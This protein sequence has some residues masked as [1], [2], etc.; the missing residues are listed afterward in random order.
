MTWLQFCVNFVNFGPVTP[1]FKNG[2]GVQPLVSFVK[3]N[4]SDKLSQ[5]PL[6]RFSPNFLCSVDM[7]SQ[8]TDLTSLFP[9]RS[10]DVVWGQNG[11]NRPTII[12]I[13]RLG[14]PKRIGV[15]LSL[16]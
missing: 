6:D 7:W 15:G 14:I 13:R 5:D 9:R 4:I 11:R 12:F 3:T 8:I 2:K 1:E 10:R 16:F